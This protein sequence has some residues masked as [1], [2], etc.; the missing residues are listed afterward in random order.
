MHGAQFIQHMWSQTCT[1][2]HNNNDRKKREYQYL[3]STYF[4][5]KFSEYKKN[6]KITHAIGA[7]CQR[8]HDMNYD[9]VT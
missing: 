3:T 1:H 2:Y 7:F 6:V 8:G 5:N 9:I 4:S